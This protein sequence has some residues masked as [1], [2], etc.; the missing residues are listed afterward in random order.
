AQGCAVVQDLG[1]AGANQAQ[2]QPRQGGLA[3]ATFADDGG[4]PGRRALDGKGEVVER[5]GHTLVEQAAAED[6]GDLVRLQQ[7]AHLVTTPLPSPFALA[8]GSSYR[9]QATQ[10]L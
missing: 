1:R 10:R 9:W 5:N 8:F 3:A 4:H 7:C 6:L 2:Q